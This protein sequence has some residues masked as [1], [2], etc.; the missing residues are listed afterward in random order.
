M[1]HFLDLRNK[2][3]PPIKVIYKTVTLSRPWYVE[4]LKIS[5]AVLFVGG[6]VWSISKAD[7]SEIVSSV[8]NLLK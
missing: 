8:L 2:V 3:Q 4:V 1:A 7:T 5:V 6:I